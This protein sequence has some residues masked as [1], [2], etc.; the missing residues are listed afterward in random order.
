MN[1]SVQLDWLLELIVI[2]L[3]KPDVTVGSILIV[4]L[5]ALLT[6]GIPFGFLTLLI[7]TIIKNLNATAICLPVSCSF[8]SPLS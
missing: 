4:S 1:L 3:Y 2:L 8:Y 7:H 5:I 6:D